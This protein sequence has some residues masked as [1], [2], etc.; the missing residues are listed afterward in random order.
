LSP[1]TISGCPA[2]DIALNAGILVDMG[3]T[4]HHLIIPAA[5]WILGAI[6]NWAGPI[7]PRVNLLCHDQLLIPEAGPPSLTRHEFLDHEHIG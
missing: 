4:E 5:V 1:E 2:I 3:V 7:S 6:A